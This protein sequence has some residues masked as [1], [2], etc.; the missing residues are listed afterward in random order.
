MSP[1]GHPIAE[2]LP[3]EH[4]RGRSCDSANTDIIYIINRKL[5]A[6]TGPIYVHH[7]H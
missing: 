1:V 6:F 7:A 4:T 5:K 3:V 2:A